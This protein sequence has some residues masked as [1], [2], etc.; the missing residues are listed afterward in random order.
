MV[1]VL[2]RPPRRETRW[3]GWQLVITDSAAIALALIAI[4]TKDPDYAYAAI[5]TYFLPTL[6]IHALHRRSGASVAGFALRLGLPV[7]G[8][9]LGFGVGSASRDAW[10]SGFAALADGAFVGLA[11]AGIAAAIDTAFLAHEEVR[12]SRARIARPLWTPYAT[13]DRDRAWLGL[14]GSF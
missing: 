5:P 2:A 6:A 12:V 14:R 13:V 10:F 8:F 11:G 9:L 3:Y 7:V 4:P 1:T